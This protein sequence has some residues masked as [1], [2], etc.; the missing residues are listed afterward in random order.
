MWIDFQERF[1]NLWDD[2]RIRAGLIII[3]SVLAAF[4]VELVVRYTLGWLASKTKTELDDKIVSAVR[5]PVFLTVLFAGLAWALSETVSG[6]PLFIAYGLLKTL[7]VLAWAGAAFK[8]SVDVLGSLSAHAGERAIVQ[9]RTVPLFDMMAKIV[10]LGATA[11]FTFLAW[12]IDVTAWLASAG[13]VGIAV[14]FAAKDSLANLIAGI[15]ILAD[16]PYKVGDF[17]VLDGALRGQV[18][19]IGIRSTRILTLDDVEITVPNA[20]I[21]NA[22]ILNEAGG[23]TAKQRIRVEVSAA[24]DSDVDHVAEVLLGCAQG[25]S[26][27]CHEPPPSVQF[28]SFGA[29]GLDFELLVWI[30]DAAGRDRIISKLNMIVFKR[31]GEAGIEIPY[32]KHDLYIKEMPPRP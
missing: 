18:T 7:L 5:R 27:L 2:A 11:Y 10:I 32:S 30:M 23:P 29:S 26:E 9:P 25:V 1:F 22:K 21:G 19:R 20:V 15:F 4:L 3:G 12:D 13:I 24:Y 14:G 28:R 31:F 8:I 6:L 17:I 16:A